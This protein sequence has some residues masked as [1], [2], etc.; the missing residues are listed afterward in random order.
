MTGP[1][2]FVDWGTSNFRAFLLD[3]DSGAELDRRVSDRGIRPLQSE[4]IASYLDRQIADWRGADTALYLAGMVGSS[5]GWRESPQ[6]D[7]PL[8]ATAL[9]S[10]LMP[11]PELPRTWILPGARVVSERKVD[12]MRGEE[13]QALGALSVMATGNATLCLP[14]THSKWVRA[15]GGRLRDFTTLMT[16]ELYQA[17][18]FHTLIG[19]PARDDRPFDPTAFALGLEAVE[20]PGGVL[21]ALFEGRSRMLQA[22]LAPEQVASYLSGVLIGEEVRCMRQSA[23]DLNRVLLIGAERLQ[24]PYHQALQYCGIEASWIDGD[25]ASQ[26]GMLAVARAHEPP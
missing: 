16:G 26:A 8:D 23:P 24:A 6:L 3:R 11:V 15:A 10:A 18:R 25:R 20:A 21:H 14:G 4:D 22:E 9:A 17:V 1:L 12:V 2:I 13:L 5:R 19:E 7:L